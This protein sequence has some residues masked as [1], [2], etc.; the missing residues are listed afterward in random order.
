MFIR[1]IHAS[2]TSR[3]QKILNRLILISKL[4]RKLY[5]LMN[6]KLNRVEIISKKF[7][8]FVIPLRDETI[9]KYLFVDGYF[10]LDKLLKVN[11]LINLKGRTLIDVGA[12]FGSICIPAVKRNIFADAIAI[13]PDVKTFEILR[14]NIYLNNLDTINA[15]QAAAGCNTGRLLFGTKHK[16]TGDGKILNK[17]NKTEFSQ[18]YLVRQITLNS[19][20]NDKIAKNALIWIDVQG[21]ES[22]VLEGATKFTS[23]KTPLVL[24]IYPLGL[25]QYSNFKKLKRSL[26]NYS[27]FANL[28]YDIY[29]PRFEP[30]SNFEI[31]FNYLEKIGSFSDYLF[32]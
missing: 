8:T 12:N 24:E 3:K 16:N 28:R 9:G 17:Y 30:I 20:F 1:F 29:E 11:K 23:A 19:L 22:R 10:D 7:E 14:R 5:W 21:F 13:E 18:S 2:N 32:I 6:R 25:N 27:Y 31:E 4:H 15:I 26:A